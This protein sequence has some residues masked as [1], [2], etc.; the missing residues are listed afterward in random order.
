MGYEWVE[1]YPIAPTE[2]EPVGTLEADDVIGQLRGGR[3]RKSVPPR[4]TALRERI[5][6][7][8]VCAVVLVS[9]ALGLAQGAT[10]PSGS[11]APT[12]SAV[13]SS[14]P[15]DPEALSIEMTKPVDTDS[16]VRFCENKS[17]LCTLSPQDGG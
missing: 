3:H 1:S 17:D 7:V 9:V 6:A 4:A 12:A 2:P 15:L 14:S 10:G 13:A 16:Y 11:S 5:E 8:A